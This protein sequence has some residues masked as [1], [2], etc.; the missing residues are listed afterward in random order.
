MTQNARNNGSKK[1]VA[2]YPDEYWKVV[3]LLATMQ[4]TPEKYPGGVRNYADAMKELV[5]GYEELNGPITA[6][7]REKSKGSDDTTI[8]LIGAEGLDKCVAV[9]HDG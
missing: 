7:R 5:R 1:S 9:A 6:P 3:D 8:H 4:E 2:A